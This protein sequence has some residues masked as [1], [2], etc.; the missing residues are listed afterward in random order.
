MQKKVSIGL[1][2]TWFFAVASFVGFL[3]VRITYPNVEKGYPSL[4]FGLMF[5][6]SVVCLVETYGKMRQNKASESPG[7]KKEPT[8]EDC[9]GIKNTWF[10]IAVTCAYMLLMNVLGFLIGTILMMVL[11][12]VC[13]GYRKPLPI[14]LTSAC[15][16]VFVYFLFS[17][18]YIPIP[19]G[20][21]AIF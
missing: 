21:L 5:I 7:V 13:L 18:L 15:C 12:P 14:I 16:I 8:K 10:V 1:I 19:E 3:Y 11:V 4:I 20:L 9:L 6:F 2:T 17:K